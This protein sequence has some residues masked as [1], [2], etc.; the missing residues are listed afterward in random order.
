MLIFSVV[1]QIDQMT[2]PARVV[3]SG[4]KGSGGKKGEREVL[5]EK[6]DGVE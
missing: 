2:K 6:A 3:F 5:I 4:K 1:F